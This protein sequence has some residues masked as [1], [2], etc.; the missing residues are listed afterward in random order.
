MPPKFPRT[1]PP[2]RRS[3]RHRHSCCG[4]P[5]K[6]WERRGRARRRPH[7]AG[8]SIDDRCGATPPGRSTRSESPTADGVTCGS[9]FPAASAPPIGLDNPEGQRCPTWA[10][11][12]PDHPQPKLVQTDERRQIRGRAGSVRHVEVFRMGGVGTSILGRPRPL[13]RAPTRTV[14]TPSSREESRSGSRSWPRGKFWPRIV[15]AWPLAP[16][17]AG[18]GFPRDGLSRRRRAPVHPPAARRG[19]QARRRSCGPQ[20]RRIAR[21]RP[22]RAGDWHTGSCAATSARPRALA[23]LVRNDANV[24]STSTA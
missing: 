17:G 14:P 10:G 5:A 2:G 12:L 11:T 18:S 19:V 3:R 8:Y 16:C 23:P 4:T 7:P 6:S 22:H 24:Y 20:L 13:P 15:A 9:L 21:A 1:S